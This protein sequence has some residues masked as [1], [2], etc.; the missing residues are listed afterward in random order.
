MNKNKLE[1]IVNNSRRDAIMEKYVAEHGGSFKN[2]RCGW[3]YEEP[4][5]INN[6]VEKFEKRAEKREK[7]VKRKLFRKNK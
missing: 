5:V 4:K 6:Q 2:G 7:E 3:E 1:S